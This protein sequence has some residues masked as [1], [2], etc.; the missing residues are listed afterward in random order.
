M[1]RSILDKGI[2]YMEIKDLA[3]EDKNYAA[4]AYDIILEGKERTLALGKPKY[5]FSD[6][7]IIY[8]PIYLIDN[9]KVDARIGIYE[10]FVN[11]FPNILDSD[12]DVD[13]AKL[14]KPLYFSYVPELLKQYDILAASKVENPL[15]HDKFIFCRK[16]QL[17][18]HH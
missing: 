15:R 8:F 5:T 2:N 6:K 16:I 4:V 9:N 3:D 10:I 18:H 7:N 11:D 12:G 1:V 17:I 13:V 14:N